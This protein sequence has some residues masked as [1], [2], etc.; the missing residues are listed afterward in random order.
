MNIEIRTHNLEVSDFVRSHVERRLGF[1][2]ARFGNRTDRVLVRLSDVNGPHRGGIDKRCQIE[3]GVRPAA[4]V[5]VEDTDADWMTS[6]DRAA[7]RASRAVARLIVCTRF[8]RM[9]AR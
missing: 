6:V 7:D 2:L 3:V 1:A 5:R 9:A 8:V 4:N